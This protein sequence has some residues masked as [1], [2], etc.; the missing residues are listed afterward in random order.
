MLLLLQRILT[1][2][3]EG[4]IHIR[5]GYQVHQTTHTISRL[6]QAKIELLGHDMITPSANLDES[7]SNVE[8]K[9]ILKKAAGH[10]LE[11]IKQAPIV[12][13]ALSIEEDCQKNTLCYTSK[14][15]INRLS[16]KK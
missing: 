7:E 16:V 2:D 4:R 12:W 15:E 10:Y 9:N 1:K 13:C 8:Y 3:K 6:V 14:Q 5:K 11:F